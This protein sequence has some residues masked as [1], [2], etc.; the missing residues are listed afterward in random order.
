MI[1]LLQINDSSTQT[2]ACVGCIHLSKENRRLNN[3]WVTAKIKLDAERRETARLHAVLDSISSQHIPEDE[4]DE[5]EQEIEKEA[6]EEIDVDEIMNESGDVIE[7]DDYVV[8]DDG[9]IEGGENEE[10]LNE[11]IAS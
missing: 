6:E 8:E 3:Y 10:G 5:F 9:Y 1:F 2:E 11:T 7:D 4:L